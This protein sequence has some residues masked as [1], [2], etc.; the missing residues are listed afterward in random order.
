MTQLDP[1]IIY[2]VKLAM[3]FKSVEPSTPIPAKKSSPFKESKPEVDGHYEEEQKTQQQQQQDNFTN[4]TFP[5]T[6]ARIM[7]IKSFPLKSG[8]K[9]PKLRRDNVLSLLYHAGKFSTTSMLSYSLLTSYNRRA[10][11]QSYNGVVKCDYFW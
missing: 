8:E 1:F 2:T 9:A 6:M 5:E 3:D 7:A 10:M 4:P 11:G